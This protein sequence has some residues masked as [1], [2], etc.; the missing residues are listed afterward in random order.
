MPNQEQI[1]TQLDGLK[2]GFGPTPE[3]MKLLGQHRLDRATEIEQPAAAVNARAIM[4]TAQ[5]DIDARAGHAA[6][7]AVE[8]AKTEEVQ[9]PV[10]V[11]PPH[12]IA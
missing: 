5:R 3:E 4:E 7:I 12:E 1:K 2:P 11:Q 10:H 9:I 6:H 8:A